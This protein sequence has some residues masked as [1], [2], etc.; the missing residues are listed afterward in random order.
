MAFAPSVAHKPVAAA[1]CPVMAATE[2]LATEGGLEARGA[3]FTRLRLLLALLITHCHC[4]SS[5]KDCGLHK[6]LF[7]ICDIDTHT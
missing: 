5:N 3:I 4:C 6:L 2:A 1:V 7:P